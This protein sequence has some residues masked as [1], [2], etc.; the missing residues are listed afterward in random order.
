MFKTKAIICICIY[1]AATCVYAEE[2]R[3]SI[4]PEVLAQATIDA[5]VP[6]G[7]VQSSVSET[8]QTTQAPSDPSV[9]KEGNVSLDFRDADIRNVLRIL[10]F[11]SGVNIVASPEVTGLVTIQLNDVP[12][13]QALE[14]ILETYGY[15]YD[16][17]GNIITVTTIENLKKRREDALLLADQKPLI[18][19]TFVLNYG[20]A[21]EIIE[22]IEKMKSDRG[23]IDYDE[24]TNTMI[25]RDIADN[26]ELIEGVIAQLDKITPQVLIEAKII[27]TTL[28]DSDKLG[29]D[30]VAKATVTGSK[31][32]TVWPFVGNSSTSNKF[33][34]DPFPG[35]TDKTTDFTYGTI[36]FNQLSATLE[37]LK[38]LTDTEILSNPRIVTLDNQAANIN[39][40]TQYP[41]PTYTYNEE[42]AKLQVSGWEYM[43]I[44]IIFTV[45][46]HVNSAGFITLEIEPK[47]TEI[48]DFVTVENTSLPRLSNE[49]AKTRVMI[50]DGETLVIAG[51][52][53]DKVTEI[54]K[55]IPFIGDIPLIGLLFRK[56]EDTVSK[57]D[58]IIFLT[59]HIIT[60]ETPPNS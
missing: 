14:V 44:G 47:V 53:K 31:R 26:V 6:V 11:K 50:K 39:V 21:S 42:Q 49:S 25:I 13:R 7:E 35:T 60:T 56:K 9:S 37:F 29:I 27:E 57:T 40:G 54:D 16:Q 1:V 23:S 32:P 43:D 51:L 36:N 48:L 46:P 58:L 28:S 41:I 55:R 15:G 24:R 17:K 12:W 45:I 33:L 10:S 3:N 34:P 8:A 18:T 20:K 52:V 38:S 4:Q 5:S 59:P 19:K 22:S 30:W 2:S